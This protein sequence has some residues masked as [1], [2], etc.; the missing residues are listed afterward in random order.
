MQ[1]CSAASSTRWHLSERKLC[2]M[3]RRDDEKATCIPSIVIRAEGF[4]VAFDLANLRANW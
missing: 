4:D 1:S 2:K 3:H